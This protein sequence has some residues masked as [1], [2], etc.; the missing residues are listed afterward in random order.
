[1]TSLRE[2]YLCE[3]LLQI[4]FKCIFIMASFRYPLFLIDPIYP[5]FSAANLNE[6]TSRVP[7]R[8]RI[9][10]HKSDNS[11]WVTGE[12]KEWSNLTNSIILL[13]LKKI[14]PKTSYMNI[15]WIIESMNNFRYHHR[16]LA[17][18]PGFWNPL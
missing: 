10:K 16:G 11:D 9:R 18:T 6:W 1:M 3:K 14:E 2:R 12:M 17:W 4:F 8:Y 7:R 15:F 13:T 5:T